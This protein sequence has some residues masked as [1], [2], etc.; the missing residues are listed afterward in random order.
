MKRSSSNYIII[1]VILSFA[2]LTFLFGKSKVTVESKISVILSGPMV[3]YSTH[4]EVKLWVQTKIPAKVY[5]EYFPVGESNRKK[6][7]QETTTRHDQGNVAHLLADELEPG[8]KYSYLLYVDGNPIEPIN[9]QEF[10]TQPIWIGK[11]SGPP[12]FRFALGSCAFVNDSKYDTQ[13]K[14]YGGDYQIFHS[15]LSQNPEFMLW[16][17]DNIYLREPD[18]DSRTGFIY[19]YTQQRALPELQPLLAKV[20]N[21]AIL[22]DHDWGPND[23]DASFWLRDTAEEMFKLFWA[24]PNYAKKGLYG[25][26]TWGDAQFFLLD[27]RSFRT[28]N[29]NKLGKRSYLGDRQLDWLINALIFSKY[30]FKFVVAGGQVLNPLQVFENYSTYSEERNQ[31]LNAIKKQKLKNVIFLTGDRHF[32]ELSLLEENGEEPIYDLTVSPLTSSTYPPITER[33]PLRVQN[34]LV[35]DKRNFGMI[36]VTGPLKNRKLTIRIHDFEGK[37]LWTREIN[38]R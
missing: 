14:P 9:K 12:D 31:L 15:I 29:D 13:P 35:D 2:S 28:A 34:T 26:F 32:T 24:N 6:K 8:K 33:N 18:W 38:A 27:D 37:E 19:R 20:H 25:S 1:A 21:Y 36:E 5:A 16:M 17:G 22:D 7:T 11:Q 23:G 4:K 30:T 3:G 10:R